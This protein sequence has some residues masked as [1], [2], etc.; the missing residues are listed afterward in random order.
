MLDP[1]THPYRDD[2]AAIE[3][4]GK[5]QAANFVQGI[6]YRVREGIAFIHQT[7]D[8]NGKAFTQ[9]L[10]GE[11]FRVYKIENGFAWGQLL[12][13]KYVGYIERS[14]LFQTTDKLTHKA[15]KLHTHIYSVPDLKTI[16]VDHLTLNSYVYVKKSEKQFSEI[17]E[18]RWIVTSHFTDQLDSLE[19]DFVTVAQQF[20][21]RPY[22][23]GGKS[24]LGIDCS[25]LVQLSLQCAGIAAPR[26]SDMQ[27]DQLGSLVETYEP[28]QRGDLVFFP[29]HVGIM[30]N[31][32]ELLHANA[33]HMCVTIEPLKTVADRSAKDEGKGII[34]VKRL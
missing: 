15:V 3:L 11:T 7:P 28:L 26:D 12:K 33:T 21:N 31:D 9:A 32:K 27:R 22:L 4:Q 18:N 24:A 10:Y 17:D 30:V 8:V 19:K 5:V 20:L 34:A 16:P 2:I 29:G 25:G 14:S 1:R 6:D 23:W 13:D